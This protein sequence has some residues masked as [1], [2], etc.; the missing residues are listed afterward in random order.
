MGVAGTEQDFYGRR[1]VA[2][3]ELPEVVETHRVARGGG[4]QNRE[5]TVLSFFFAPAS[6]LLSSSTCARIEETNF[7]NE[8]NCKK[9]SSK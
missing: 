2:E 3:A 7:L 4:C 8:I 1:N 6:F 5:L 9:V